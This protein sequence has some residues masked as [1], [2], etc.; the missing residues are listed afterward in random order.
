VAVPLQL[1]F[2]ASD[3]AALAGLIFKHA[4]GKPLRDDV[5]SRIAAQL[6]SLQLRSMRPW[7]GSLAADPAHSSV[8]YVAADPLECAAPRPLLLRIAAASSPTSALFPNPLLIGRMRAGFGPEV[9]VNAIPFGPSDHDNIRKFVEEIDRAFL[10]RPQGLQPP[11]SVATARPAEVLPAAFDAFRYS[12]HTRGASHAVIAPVD[13]S[14]DT[15][16]RT[17][18][19]A[20]WAAIRAGWREGYALE[21]GPVIRAAMPLPPSACLF[22]SL[23]A[24]SDLNE[25]LAR[26]KTG[27]G[28]WKRFD[29]SPEVQARTAA[30]TAALDSA[31]G[32]FARIILDF[33][34]R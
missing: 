29:P 1:P 20:A 24:E 15:M 27:H 31:T 12:L 32:D 6:S 17:Y 2:R 22:T 19:A 3:A 21:L 7:I 16:L 26:I 11:F 25:E 13:L 5:R 10:P 18:T 14:D 34:F 9:V 23:I 33:G 28:P 8:F 30:L 4:E